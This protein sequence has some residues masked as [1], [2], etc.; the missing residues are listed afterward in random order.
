RSRRRRRPSAPPHRADAPARRRPPRGAHPG[1][2]T[3]TP[4]F[5][6]R[7]AARKGEPMGGLPHL[8]QGARFEGAD[9]KP[10]KAER[11]GPTFENVRIRA[12][13]RWTLGP[14][15]EPA[16]LA[17]GSVAAGAA[18][19]VRGLRAGAR[20]VA[21]FAAGL[22]PAVLR[23]EVLR[24]GAF[25]A[26][27]VFAAGLRAVVF[28]AARLLAAVAFFAV[29]RVAVFFAAAGF[30]AAVALVAVERV[31]VFFAAAGFLAAVAFFAVVRVVAFFAAGFLAAVAFF[32]VVV[33]FAAGFLAAVAF[34]AAVL[35]RA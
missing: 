17:A 8:H 5:T 11:P 22:A 23:A 18:L 20:L 13:M 32:A 7:A 6:P 14:I 1:R 4:L 21:V 33:F 19:G 12:V 25:F 2:E 24:A 9:R 31:V 27:A 35:L 29:V 34:F 3:W 10:R 26:V 16:Q 15:R 28:F 30:L